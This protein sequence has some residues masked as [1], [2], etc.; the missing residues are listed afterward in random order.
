MSSKKSV[1]LILSIAVLSLFLSA[2]AF[3]QT[4]PQIILTPNSKPVSKG[5][6]LAVKVEL[7]T[8]KGNG[9]NSYMAILSYPQ[10]KLEFVSINTDGSPFAMSLVSKG[11]DGKVSMIRGSTKTVEG[12][13]LAGTVNFKA[14]SQADASDVKVTNESAIIRSSDN[15]NILP[16]S[17]VQNSKP[18][19]SE[20]LPGSTIQEG[21][22]STSNWINAIF[23]SIKNFFSSLFK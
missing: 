6:D 11:G 10:D 20:G 17:T 13:L 3:A 8:G 23:N 1:S 4:T 5:E 12:K 9:T 18:S 15:S 19:S 16:G 21:A 22:G 14:K 7:E 2:E